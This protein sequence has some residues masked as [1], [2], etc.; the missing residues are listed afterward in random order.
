MTKPWHG[1]ASKLGLYAALLILLTTV[2]LVASLV[3]RHQQRQSATFRELGLSLAKTVAE[4]AQMGVFSGDAA[5]LEHVAH[6]A[7]SF[8]DVAGVTVFDL[9][10]RVLSRHGTAGPAELPTTQR[11]P[12]PTMLGELQGLL[13]PANVP[14]NFVAPVLLAAGPA[15]P[16]SQAASAPQEP[17]G[18]V[19][20]SL[21]TASFRQ[22]LLMFLETSMGAAALMGLLGMAGMAVLARVVLKPLREV[23]IAAGH[24]AAG[25]LDHQVRVHS[26]DEVGLLAQAF[27]RMTAQ[28]R[29]ARDTL[30][31]R[32]AERTRMLEEASAEAYRLAKHDALTGLP[33]RVLLRERL[34]LAIAT[35]REHGHSV[36]LFFVDVDHFKAVNDSLGHESGDLVLKAI[37]QRLT[38]LVAHHG[39]AARLAGDEFVLVREALPADEGRTLAHALAQRVLEVVSEPI[40]VPGQEVRMGSSVGVALYPG[41]AQDPTTLLRAADMAMYAAKGGG[42]MG[43][44]LFSADM[45]APVLE[46]LHLETDL[47]RA[48]AEG[49]LMLWY[50]PQWSMD[51]RRLVGAEALLRWNHPHRGLVPPGQFIPVAEASGLIREIGAWVLDQATRDAQAWNAANAAQGA[52]PLRVAVNVSASQLNRSD[53]VETVAAALAAHRLPPH[54]LELELTESGIVENPEHGLQVLLRLQA[55]GVRLA[56]DDFGTGF[57]SLSYLTRLPVHSLKIDRSFVAGLPAAQSDLAVVQAICAMARKLGLQVVAEGVETQAQLQTLKHT[58]C[59]M[60]QGFLFAKPMPAHEFRQ[61]CVAQPATAH[62]LLSGS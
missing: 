12:E 45:E 26:R 62:P 52:A 17:Q 13:L 31:G 37:A 18:Y 61:R 57:S 2:A 9:S 7:S 10:G 47:R 23:T 21:S 5:E 11:H 4:Q 43:V 55:L 56:I 49:E 46:R 25:D 38:A 33:N 22:Q 44:Q 16:G 8:P 24:V 19:V 41:D 20:V 36:A 48:L 30:E 35:A 14:V 39:F 59:D 58:G 15:M 3:V 1:L 29:E 54:L 53:I 34:D 50:Q 42:R 28:L 32:V 6:G 51:G 60:V 27:N 40:A